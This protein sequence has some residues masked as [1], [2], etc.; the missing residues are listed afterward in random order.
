M[1]THTYTQLLSTS[2]NLQGG[3]LRAAHTVV[4]AVQLW[5]CGLA[6]NITQRGREQGKDKRR[7]QRQ[8]QDRGGKTR[9]NLRTWVLIP[10]HQNKTDSRRTVVKL[11]MSSWCSIS[12]SLTKEQWI[13]SSSWLSVRC[14]FSM[15]NM[16]NDPS[17]YILG[18]TKN[19]STWIRCHTIALFYQS[20][21]AESSSIVI[22]HR[23][24]PGTCGLP[25][26][27]IKIPVAVVDKALFYSANPYLSFTYSI[28]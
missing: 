25:V 17:S 19:T 2:D 13:N 15:W 11:V 4:S 26:W 14:C 27:D 23:Q 21:P 20:H 6:E 8:G 3:H 28:L 12:S 16:I 22:Y 7:G 24:Q 10:V 18:R 5:C 9:T 1:H